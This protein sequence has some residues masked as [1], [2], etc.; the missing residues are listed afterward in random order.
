MASPT[1]P[2]PTPIPL[3]EDFPV[4]WESPE[5]SMLLWEQEQMHLPHAITPLGADLVQAVLPQNITAG[6]QDAGAPVKAALFKVFN[7]YFYTGTIPD[8][9]KIEGTEERV[10]A[11]VA[12]RG[13]TMYDTW[14]REYLP[15]V[16][17]GSA[18]VLGWDLER[19]TD[20]QLGGYI[21]RTVELLQRGFYL[22]FRLFPGFFTAAAF[23]D[24]CKGLLGVTDLEALEMLQG[25]E[26]LSVESGS[27]L[28]QLAHSA[29]PEVAGVIRAMDSAGALQRLAE[30]PEG[31]AFLGRLEGYLRVYGWRTGSF[32]ISQPSWIERPDLA[33]DQVRLMLDVKHDPIEDQRAAAERARAL[34]EAARAKLA[35]DPAALGQFEFLLNGAKDYTKLQENHNFYLD[36]KF[37]AIARRPFVEA[38]RRLAAAGVTDADDDAYYLR[39]ADLRAFLDG[40]RSD[41]RQQVAAARAERERWAG[42]RP[43]LAIGS[44]PPVDEASSFAVRFFGES[45]VP[46]SDDAKVLK[47]TASSRGTV[48]AVARVI[49][50]LDEA[51]RLNEG[52][53]LVCDMTTPAW[54]PLFAI[55]GG[56]VADSGGALSHCAVVAREYGVP[57]VTGTR[58]ATATI[59]DGATIT[60]DG[61]NGTVTLH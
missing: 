18:E 53:I 13:F 36:Q 20:A 58:I 44:R 24:A 46:E 60:L 55:V 15:E 56:I 21:D 28:W 22:H 16:E 52:E 26:N 10:K 30:F 23:A 50:T 43:P 51:E 27:K 54:T 4:T 2:M 37:I 59:P 40:D 49:H 41:R 39:L 34:I 47:G 48:T 14:V 38:G 6:L 29:E 3:P 35:S 9:S 12:E 57:C 11:A 5:E 61:T 19:A 32:D 42:V 8:F 33:L 17:A 1:M 45:K 25:S 7:G 31:R